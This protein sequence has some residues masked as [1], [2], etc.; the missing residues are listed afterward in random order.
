MPS[1]EC[2]GSYQPACWRARDGRL[3]FAT[4][5]GAVAIQP[6]EVTQNL[7][8]PPVVIEEMLIDGVVQDLKNAI[9]RASLTQV[10]KGHPLELLPALDATPGT[11]QVEFRF[12]AL[13]FNSQA[14]FRYKLV[15]LDN[16]WVDDGPR[17]SSRGTVQYGFLRPGD[18]QF[19]VTAR[20]N[21]G[22]WNNTGAA[23]ILRVRPYFY[24]TKTFII[25]ASLAAAGLLLLI[26]RA[27]YKRRLREEMQR[28]ERQRAV[29]RD[30]ARIAKDIH[31]D[32]GAGLTQITLLSELAKHDPPEEI[33]GH[34]TQISGTAREL[35]R[36]MD[37]IVW[38]IDPQNDTLEGL[39][40]YVS[41]FA[42]QYLTLAGIRCR[43]DV[44]V[45]LPA[46]ML[47]AEVRHNLYLAIKETLNNI[48]KHSGATVATLKLEHAAGL[49]TLT[50][51]DDGRGLARAK[52][53]P[54]APSDRTSSGHGLVNMKRRLQDIGGRCELTSEPGRGTKVQ[55]T[56][57]VLPGS[58]VL[59]T[60][61]THGEG[62]L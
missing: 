55:F 2:S 33:E 51:E 56:I 8:P 45:E 60:A 6:G 27:I 35:T 13:S 7:K 9:R 32:L 38:A 53:E 39:I 48:V 62:R 50:I 36:A 58:P 11:R 26:A 41:K 4:Q 5:A 61:T 37:E 31:D 15:G 20:N 18:Y 1:L 46:Y 57:R 54:V 10:E 44:P 43:L 3:W 21:E 28:V 23:L 12:T 30:R 42:Q 16:D 52:N 24:E 40:T 19:H 34:V 29:E 47:G 59:A 22:V 25:F 14:R 17:E 49:V